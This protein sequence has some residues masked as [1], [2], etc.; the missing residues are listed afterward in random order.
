MKQMPEDNPDIC[1]K[2]QRC[3]WTLH[4]FSRGFFFQEHLQSLKLSQNSLSVRPQLLK[5][6]LQP[7]TTILD[8]ILDAVFIAL[9]L[10]SSFNKI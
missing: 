3:D 7:V 9:C 8:V 4:Y 2:S 6:L 10:V 1:F 5:M